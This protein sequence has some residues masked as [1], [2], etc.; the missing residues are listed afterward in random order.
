MLNGAAGSDS[1]R[2]A[3]PHLPGYV[4]RQADQE[5]DNVGGQ[6]KILH[7]RPERLRHAFEDEFAHFIWGADSGLVEIST[8]AAPLY[9]LTDRAGPRKFFKGHVEGGTQLGRSG[10]RRKR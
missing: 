10:C 3:G 9:I 2:V 1:H 7:V 8:V 4:K 5:E 6:I